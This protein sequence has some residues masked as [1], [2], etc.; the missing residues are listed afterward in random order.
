MSVSSIIY[1]T[2]AQSRSFEQACVKA[3]AVQRRFHKKWVVC[4]EST[5]IH[6]NIQNCLIHP[7]T[8]DW[9]HHVTTNSEWIL[10]YS[11]IT[12][13]EWKSKKYHINKLKTLFLQCKYYVVSLRCCLAFIAFSFLRNASSSSF[14]TFS[15]LC[16]SSWHDFNLSLSGSQQERRSSSHTSSLVWACL[17]D[18]SSRNKT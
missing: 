10:Y 1:R 4:Y 14:A 16:Q 6:A 3:I 7:V 18:E 17:W 12:E 11:T 9:V 15:R 13:K 5:N 8:G 2:N